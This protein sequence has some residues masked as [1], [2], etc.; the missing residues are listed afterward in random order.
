MFKILKHIKEL[1]Y[2][3][4]IGLLTLPIIAI[5]TGFDI[6]TSYFLTLSLSRFNVFEDNYIRTK[7]E[8]QINAMLRGMVL[9][10]KL[11]NQ[12]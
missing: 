1:K 8:K 3:Y 5:V 4:V 12:F 2:I 9:N 6:K 7:V 10:T 11:S